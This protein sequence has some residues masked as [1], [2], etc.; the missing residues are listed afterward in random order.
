M[1]ARLQRLLELPAAGGV[2]LCA[3]AA[4]ALALAN[5]PQG[6]LYEQLLD[7]PVAVQFGALVLAKPLLLWINDGLMAVFF[8]LVGLE[9]KREVMAGSLSTL[10][11]AALPALAAIGGMVGPSLVYLACTHA[12][13][14][15]LRG[16]AIPAATDIAFALGVLA[17]VGSRAPASLKTFL[18]AL[19]IIDDI[20]AIIIIAVFYTYDLSLIAL[21]LAGAGVLALVALNLCGVTRRVGYML[22]GAFVWV[23]VLKSGVHATLAGLAV[24]FAIPLNAAGGGSPL[25]QLEH[26][27]HHWVTF[28]VLPVFAFANAGVR[29]AD[30]ALADLR[31]PVQIGIALGLLIGKPLGVLGA[32]WAAVRLRIAPLPAGAQ[33]PQVCGLALL[34]GIGFTMSLFI[35]TLAFPLEGYVGDV[36]LA[37]LFGSVISALAGYAVL[38]RTGT[39]K[40]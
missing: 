40:P 15:V 31:H 17:L 30:I 32:I 16:W 23:C 3:A 2:V 6:G 12:D 19:A 18:L 35:A 29:F 10:P 33:W 28:G 36:R 7:L 11:G 27:L 1:L 9:V 8:M 39:A 26:D 22:V 34:T 37:V 4:L 13:P 20:G 5:S 24:G 38:R 14:T 21:E 25:R